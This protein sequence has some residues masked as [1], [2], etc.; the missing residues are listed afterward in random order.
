M[1]GV[2]HL[3]VITHL[4]DAEDAEVISLRLGGLSVSEPGHPRVK[5]FLYLGRVHGQGQLC[6][7]PRS[8]AEWHRRPLALVILSDFIILSMTW[9]GMWLW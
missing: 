2:R 7:S 8:A 6:C 9:D 5:H 3:K 4:R 1:R